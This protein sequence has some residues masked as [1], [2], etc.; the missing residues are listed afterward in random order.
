MDCK[1][2]IQC[3]STISVWGKL[4]GLHS[5]VIDN[6]LFIYI[7]KCIS[8][9]DVN[10]II[11]A[12][13]LPVAVIVEKGSFAA[14]PSV[15][16]NGKGIQ[17]VV[18]KDISEKLIN[19]YAFVDGQKEKL[20]V[21]KS[22]NLI[23]NKFTVTT[24]KPKM[25]KT[26][27]GKVTYK[28]DIIHVNV[29][30]K[31]KDDLEM[32]IRMGASGIGILR[33]DWLGWDNLCPPT[34]SD[35]LNL[36]RECLGVVKNKQLNIRLFDIGGDKIP[37][38]ASAARRDIKSPLGLRGIRSSTILKDAFDNQLAAI[39]EVSKDRK[40]GIVLPMISLP[41]EIKKFKEYSNTVSPC[42]TENIVWGSMVETPSSALLVKDIYKYADFIRIGP[43]DLSQ[44][45]LA[46][47]RENISPQ[48]LSGDNLNAS[49]LKLIKIVM[50]ESRKQHKEANMCLDVEPRMPLLKKLLSVGVRTFNVSQQNIQKTFSLI[51]EINF[52]SSHHSSHHHRQHTHHY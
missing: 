17:L 46:T 50:T 39:A 9:D 6:S 42:H 3:L 37:K 36:Y 41:E 12:P 16:L 1:Y 4:V 35:H 24:V 21:S 26:V 15:L 29:D 30:G 48:H 23:K 43:G 27:V 20:Y 19:H 11:S 32:G 10:K 25:A 2:D 38:W 28:G 13:N 5:H 49:V 8:V 40:I 7:A 45:T 44:F 31:N 47:L 18:S 51:S 14:H 33:T 22:E 52:S 34:Y